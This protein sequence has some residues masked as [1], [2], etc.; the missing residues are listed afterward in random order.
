MINEAFSS[1]NSSLSSGECEFQC[2]YNRWKHSFEWL[3]N[4]CTSMANNQSHWC[5][6]GEKSYSLGYFCIS[7][8][9]NSAV[10]DHVS[11]PNVMAVRVRGHNRPV[12]IIDVNLCFC[13]FMLFTD[14]LDNIYFPTYHRRLRESHK[15]V[16]DQLIA[17]GIPYLHRPAG[18]FLWAD[19][20]QVRGGDTRY[21]VS[22]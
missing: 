1:L 15:A 11:A 12:L 13:S 10:V 20:S 19:L 18:L 9:S 4:Q 17:L 3:S 7:F 6:L 8:C 16:T 22:T 21:T 14:F 5:K 2:T